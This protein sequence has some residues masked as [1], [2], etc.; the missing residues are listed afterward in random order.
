MR[1]QPT[2]AEA[3][4]WRAVRG[5]KICGFRFRRQDPFLGFIVD[6]RCPSC[7]LVVEV[8]GGYHALRDATDKAREQAIVGAGYSVIR[9]ANEE[10]LNDLPK[11]VR[12]LEEVCRRWVASTRAAPDAQVEDTEA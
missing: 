12:R 9:F 11:V 2:D 5:G 10:V 3:T 8:D 6:F 7:R 4:L 1:L